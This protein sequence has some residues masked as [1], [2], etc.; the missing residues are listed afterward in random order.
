MSPRSRKFPTTSTKSSPRDIPGKK[1][2]TNLRLLLLY[3]IIITAPLLVYANSFSGP[4]IF[5]DIDSIPQNPT[6]RSL[7]PIWEPLSPPAHGQAVQR[8]PIV[9]LSLAINYAIGHLE[10]KGYHAFNLAIHIL[11]GLVLFGILRRTL[12]SQRLREKFA[13]DAE[14]LALACTLIWM[15]HPLQ[16]E[17]VTYIIQR[18]ELLAGIF[19]LLTIYSLIRASSTARPALWYTA[20]I[21][22]CLLGMGSKE[23]MV[24]APLVVF[25]YDR[26]FLSRSFKELL[27]KRWPLYLGLAAT[28]ALLATLIPHGGEGTAVFGQGSMS[29]DYALTQFQSIVTYLRLCFWPAPLILDYGTWEPTLLRLALPYGIIVSIL[30]TATLFAIRYRPAIGFLGIWFFAILAPSSSFVPVMGQATAEKRMYLPLAAIVIIVILSAYSLGKRILAHRSTSPQ[31][32][33]LTQRSLPYVLLLA[34]LIPLAL[35]TIKRNH[36]YRNVF[37]IWEDTIAKRPHNWRVHNEMG[38]VYSRKKEYAQALNYF[39]T[40]IRLAPE[41]PRSYNN[42]G[43]AYTRL[44][45]HNLAIKD[46]LKTVELDP[47]LAEGYKNLGFTYNKM[48]NYEQAIIYFNKAIEVSSDVAE[49]YD[50]RAIAHWHTGNFDQASKDFNKAISLNPYD[51]K[52]FSNRGFTYLEKRDYDHAIS[53]FSRAIDLDPT[54]VRA[55]KNRAAANIAKGQYSQAARDLGKAI[56]LNPTDPLTY[57]DRGKILHRLGKVKQALDHYRQALQLR[58]DWPEVLNNL[59]WI[60]ATNQDPKIRDGNQA[61]RLAKRACQLENYKAFATVDTLAVA[62]AELGKFEQALETAKTAMQ[63]AQKAG[64]TQFAQDISRRMDLYKAKRPW[65]ESRKSNDLDAPEPRE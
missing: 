47:Q 25:L 32:P 29:L 33:T 39:N 11:T 4:F 14:P 17:A 44:G 35:L 31:L 23:V 22:C 57:K 59:A 46:F 51:A 18:T 54:F 24:S 42:R 38:G 56:E 64:L 15:L 37:S 41:Q 1:S 63:L 6:I 40:A 9:N 49:F 3:S 10:V 8:R 36:D 27:Q 65:R 45:K 16:T 2:S 50:N 19:Y 34:L 55:Y 30:L 13:Q 62:Y 48:E 20:A 43:A 28:W 60:L 58:P 52:Q 21:S 26:I 61:L 12:L 5:D 7:W 53:D